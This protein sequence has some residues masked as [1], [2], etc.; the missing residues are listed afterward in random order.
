VKIRLAAIERGCSLRDAWRIAIHLAARMEPDMVC[1]TQGCETVIRT[2]LGLHHYG[3]P[4]V[5]TDEQGAFVQ[6][7]KCHRRIAWPP[8]DLTPDGFSD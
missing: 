8:F 2:K 7:P 3:E 1:P 5:W 4:N 6:C